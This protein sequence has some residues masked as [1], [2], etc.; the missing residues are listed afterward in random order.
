[1]PPAPSGET[2]SN[3]PT[4]VPSASISVSK[5]GDVHY[6]QQRISNGYGLRRATI[7]IAICGETQRSQRADARR[8]RT[9]ETCG[10]VPVDA[11]AACQSV[12]KPGDTNKPGAFHLP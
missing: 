9:G 5:S 12:S 2:I 10:C 3:G 6:T 4:R 1:M 11:D 7:A 8:R